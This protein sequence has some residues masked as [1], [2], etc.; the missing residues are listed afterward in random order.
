VSDPNK[1]LQDLS[2]ATVEKEIVVKLEQI[3]KIQMKK[4]VTF[5]YR[6]FNKVE[7]TFF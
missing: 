6:I 7:R 2:Q 5:F 1:L 4:G 3:L